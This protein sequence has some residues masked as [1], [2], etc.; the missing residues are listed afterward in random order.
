[1]RRTLFK[2]GILSYIINLKPKLLQEVSR[3]NV[4]KSYNFTAIISC[5]TATMIRIEV[6]REM[7]KCFGLKKPS[8]F[9]FSSPKDS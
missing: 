7:G 4:W 5:K 8:M 1:M 2:I 6:S 9:L 3:C